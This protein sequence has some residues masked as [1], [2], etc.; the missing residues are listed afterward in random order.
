MNPNRSINPYKFFAVAAAGVFMGTLEGSILN[1]ALPTIAAEF[2]VPIDQIAWL[3]M[4]YSLTLVSLMMI[5][6]GWAA[7]TGYRFAYT[8]GFGFFIVGTVICI[9]SQSFYPLLA[10][11]VVQAVGSAMCQA[12]GMGLIT[13]AFPPEQR[14]KGIGLLAMV[15]AAGL[16]TGPPL[17][18]FLL[19]VWPWQ[20]IFIASLPAGVA[21]LLLSLWVF[22]GFEAEVSQRKVNLLS[23]SALSTALLASMLWLSLTDEYALLDWRMI[24]LAMTA[25]VAGVLFYRSETRSDAPLIGLELLHNRDFMTAVMA[26]FAMF[27]ALGGIA[28]LMPFY[29]QDVRGF[30]PRQIGFFLIILPATMALVA[31][32]SGRLSDRWGYRLLTTVGMMI[33]LIGQMILMNLDIS[34]STIYI[35][36]GLTALGIGIG[37]F[38]SPNLSALMGSVTDSQRPIASGVSS[39]TRVIGMATGI[40]LSTALFA[41]Y[42]D[43][44]GALGGED[45]AFVASLQQ[46]LRLSTAPTAL[47]ILLCLFRRN[48]L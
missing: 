24:L 34:S 48:R 42:Q 26:S 45:V 17:G 23:A 19:D 35:A 10:G 9:F 15:V 39:T 41:L 28:I 4:A 14:G 1:V 7:R 2:G 38:N 22:R 44:F 12:V 3:T 13:A 16:M 11:R 21:G 5:F 37:I 29:L 27:S 18:G 36:T 20:S 30:I 33:I 46:V 40:A 6:G 25:P 47:G 31:Q 43:R 32:I 8:F